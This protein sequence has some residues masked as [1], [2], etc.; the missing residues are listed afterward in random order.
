MDN[1][2]S[3][4]EDQFLVGWSVF[5]GFVEHEGNVE[6]QHPEM[7]PGR[8][9]GRFRGKSVVQRRLVLGILA[10]LCVHSGIKQDKMVLF[11]S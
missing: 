11:C 10:S 6:Y 3:F 5:I 1:T 8:C 7:H 9:A 2:A 4:M